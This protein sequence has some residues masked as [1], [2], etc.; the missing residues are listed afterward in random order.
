MRFDKSVVFGGDELSAF[1]NSF[2]NFQ[3][4]YYFSTPSSA[5]GPIAQALKNS[6]LVKKTSKVVLEKPLGYSLESSK[7]INEDIIKAFNEKQ[8][9]RIDHYLGKETVALVESFG[10]HEVKLHQDIYGNDRM[11]SASKKE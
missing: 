4:I 1:L 5:F 11:I 2:P 8:I 6:G 9:Y 10:F 7:S 3:N